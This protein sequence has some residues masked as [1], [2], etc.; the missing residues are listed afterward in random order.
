MW[1]TISKVISPKT[2]INPGHMQGVV[3]ISKN[4]YDML[5]SENGIRMVLWFTVL[6]NVN[7]AVLNLLPLPVLDGGHITTSLIEMVTRR[8]VP[9]KVMLVL[10]NSFVLLLMGFMLWV[11]SK[12]IFQIVPQKENVVAPG[13]Y[14]FEAPV[15]TS[16][17]GVTGSDESTE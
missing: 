14:I 13:D 5:Q 17:S 15:K 3:G 12:D 4:Y 1:T 7:L 2:D 11:S 9:T 8:P 16:P 6:L 10:Q